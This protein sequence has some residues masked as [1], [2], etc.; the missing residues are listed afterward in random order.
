MYGLRSDST[1]WKT[2]CVPPLAW[3]QLPAFTGTG[4]P[5]SIALALIDPNVDLHV[6]YCIS[7]D[8]TL[9]YLDI[10]DNT[11]VQENNP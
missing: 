2:D 3:I 9:W 5:A 1:I 7:S 11:W 10:N 6:L 8:G 4:K